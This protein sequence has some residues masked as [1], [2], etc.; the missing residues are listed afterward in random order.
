MRSAMLRAAGAAIVL[1]LATSGCTSTRTTPEPTAPP[2]TGDA[3]TPAPVVADLS[4]ETTTL[5]VNGSTGSAPADIEVTV[6]NHGTTPV[7]VDLTFSGVPL[8]IAPTGDQWDSCNQTESGGWRTMV[9]ELSPVPASGS[10]TY[11][12]EF[13]VDFEDLY[14]QLGSLRDVGQV[15]VTPRDAQETDPADNAVQLEVCTNGCTYPPGTYD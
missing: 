2:P 1:V 10:A 6:S 12:Y 3:T 9:C 13:Q 8:G 11:R 5:R 15:S 4:L 14:G 7:G